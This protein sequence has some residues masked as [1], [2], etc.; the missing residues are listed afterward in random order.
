M[1]AYPVSQQRQRVTQ[2]HYVRTLLLDFTLKLKL[3][4]LPAS[5][6]KLL[7]AFGGCFRSV[8]VMSG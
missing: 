6:G 4:V 8:T 5:L 7:S 2:N 1:D 3:G